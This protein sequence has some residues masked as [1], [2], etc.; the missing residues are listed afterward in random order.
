MTQWLNK[1]PVYVAASGTH[2]ALDSQLPGPPL[3][4]GFDTHAP[5]AQ[6]EARRLSRRHLCQEDF[7]D[8]IMPL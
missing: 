5:V 3:Q 7:T 8:L 4:F 1:S 6:G 2:S